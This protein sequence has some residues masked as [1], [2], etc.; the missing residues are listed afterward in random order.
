MKKLFTLIPTALIAMSVATG[1]GGN[2]ALDS[3]VRKLSRKNIS[4]DDLESLYAEGVFNSGDKDVKTASYRIDDYTPGDMI[5]VDAYSDEELEQVIRKLD[6]TETFTSYDNNVVITTVDSSLNPFDKSQMSERDEDGYPVNEC[7]SPIAQKYK[8]EGVIWSADGD[9]NYVYTQD[10]KVGN[11]YSFYDHAPD[12]DG[13]FSHF[14][15]GGGISENMLAGMREAE[16]IYGQYAANVTWANPNEKFSAKRDGSKL[17]V[18]WYGDLDYDLY[19]AERLWGYEYASDDEEYQNPIKKITNEFD[20]VYIQMGIR[21]GYAYTI[22]AGFIKDAKV[23]YFGYYRILYKDANWQEGDPTPNYPMSQEEIDAVTPNLYVPE[24]IKMDGKTI[25][26]PYTGG[27]MSQLMHTVE[28]YNT[29]GDSNGDYTGKMPD[30]AKYRAADFSDSG[31][32]FDA[33]EELH[34]ND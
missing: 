15:N 4:K 7:I 34:E 26:N 31:C 8:G 17:E 24:K 32:W 27:I 13:L 33:S 28:Y 25:N 10:G 30:P 6:R 9:V 11:D 3:A 18:S 2:N 16:D 5:N 22:D 20:G 1:C 23:V 21:F 12:V 19:S 29:S 14:A